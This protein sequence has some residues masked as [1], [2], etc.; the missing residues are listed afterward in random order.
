[1][2][3][4]VSFSVVAVWASGDERWQFY[5]G[6]G[7]RREREGDRREGRHWF[8]TVVPTTEVSFQDCWGRFTGPLRVSWKALDKLIIGSLM[9]CW[10]VRNCNPATKNG[11]HSLVPSDSWWYFRIPVHTLES[12]LVYPR[13]YVWI[14]R[15]YFRISHWYIWIPR[16]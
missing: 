3:G 8:T 6:K 5:G 14:P 12:P 10:W 4:Q 13:W 15:W 16:W 2:A 1:M 7:R 11:I 9:S